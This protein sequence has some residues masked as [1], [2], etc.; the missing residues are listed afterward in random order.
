MTDTA[1]TLEQII[2]LQKQ[3]GLTTIQRR[4]ESGL[5]WNLE[6]FYGRQAMDYIESGAC[7][8]PLVPRK[9][10]WGNT[11]PARNTLKAG[12]KGTFEKSQ[13]YWQKVLNGE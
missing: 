4:I 6:G 1:L 7:F 9:D 11:V 2:D 12:T 10:Y 13:E 3:Y 8:L 5:C